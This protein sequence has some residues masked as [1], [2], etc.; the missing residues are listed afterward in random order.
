MITQIFKKNASVRSGHA[1]EEKLTGLSTS[2]VVLLYKTAI[3]RL[4]KTDLGRFFLI[5]TPCAAI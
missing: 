3:K 4:I 5:V 2:Y 1:F